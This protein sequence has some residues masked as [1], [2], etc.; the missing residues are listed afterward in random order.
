MIVK[1]RRHEYKYTR[2]T[3]WKNSGQQTVGQQTAYKDTQPHLA[4]RYRRRLLI[5]YSAINKPHQ[6]SL[7]P[8][9]SMAAEPRL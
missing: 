7:D 1:V 3:M 5:H 6:F 2:K 9:T 8:R 4:K